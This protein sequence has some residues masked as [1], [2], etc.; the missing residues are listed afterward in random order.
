MRQYSTELETDIRRSWVQIWGRRWARLVAVVGVINLV[1]VGFNLTYVPLRSLYLDYV[2]AVVQIYDPVKGIEPHPVTQD[3][4]SAVDQVRSH[5]AQTGLQDAELLPLLSTLQQKSVALIEENPFQEAAQAASFS[6]LK[7][8]IQ[9][10]TGASSAQVGLQRLWQLPYLNEKSW[11]SVDDFLQTQVEPLLRQNYYR[12]FLPTGQ[13]WDDFWRWDLFFV[14][15]FGSELLVRTLLLSSQSPGVSWGDTLARRWYEVPL[16]LPFWRWL[17]LVPVAIRLHR[18][19]LVNVEKLLGQITH[20]PAAYLSERV[21]QYMIVQLI[22]EA[23]T[24]VKD[25]RLLE[26]WQR[27]PN[28]TTIGKPEKVDQITDRLVQLIVMRV[29]PSVK[30]DIELLLRHSLQQAL[31]E[32]DVYSSLDQIPG[33]G[34]LPEEALNGIAEYL[35]EATCDVLTES[36]TDQEG[37]VILDQL[38]SDFRHALGRELRN[39]ANSQELQ[40]LATDLLEELKVN[41]VQRSPDQ[42]PETTLQEVNQLQQTTRS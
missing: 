12:E 1:L 23:Q 20:E 17:R 15:F 40:T 9:H 29:M 6:R 13:P 28:Y 24:F 21:M 3:Y 7:R 42:T 11:P 34:A 26:V 18:S 38:S 2:P 10:E 35:S 30:P 27:Q 33:F 36:Y 32:S 22:N 5:I 41:Y 8:R 14:G 37:R 16:V 31:A 25:G 39:K 4:L 19:Q